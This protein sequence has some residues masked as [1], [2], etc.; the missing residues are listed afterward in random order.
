MR[1]SPPSRSP[2]RFSGPIWGRREGATS[3]RRRP[4]PACRGKEGKHDRPQSNTSRSSRVHRLAGWSYLRSR[5][6][7]CQASAGSEWREFQGTWTAV[8]K[9]RGIPLGGNRRASIADFDGSLMLTGPSRPALGFRAEAI[10]LNDSATGMIG[11]AVWTDER[12]DQVFSELRGETTA[13]SN[14][15]FGTF[16][17]GS[18][19]YSGATGSYEFSWRFLLE[20]EDGTVQGQSMGLKGQVRA[21]APPTARSTPARETARPHCLPHLR[22][23]HRHWP[24]CQTLQCSPRRDRARQPGPRR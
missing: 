1:L 2:R 16:F 18:G 3:I 9:R 5:T 22:A 4:R 12:G 17:G 24:T 10:L 20:D 15:V 19:R 6:D 7:V 23:A 13:T 14:R 8:G 21:G 11:R